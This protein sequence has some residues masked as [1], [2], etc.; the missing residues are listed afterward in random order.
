MKKKISVLIC[1]LCGV[2]FLSGCENNKSKFTTKNLE[3]NV[4]YEYVTGNSADAQLETILGLAVEQ[5]V[6][7]EKNETIGK[8]LFVESDK[9]KINPNFLIQFY[10]EINTYINNYKE[11][12]IS[13][14]NGKAIQI[15]VDTKE[16][17]Y[18]SI[19]ENMLLIKE[20]KIVY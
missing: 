8:R 16:V 15:F 17:W 5:P 2:V 4:L 19:D 3:E 10:S 14:N 6:F 11:I 13:L 18:C 12:V 9:D 1:A 20:K 7:N